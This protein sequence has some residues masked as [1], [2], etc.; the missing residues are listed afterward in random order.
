[1]TKIYTLV[2]QKGGV[3]K[4]TAV[5]NLAVAL[6]AALSAD[7]W[8]KRQTHLTGA[9]ETAAKMHNALGITEPVPTKVEPFFSRP[10]LVPGECNPG[11]AIYQKRVMTWR[12]LGVEL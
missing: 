11:E 5:A 9:Y 1:M 6:A 7:S 4:T 10:Y 3:G 8:T 2:N 12:E